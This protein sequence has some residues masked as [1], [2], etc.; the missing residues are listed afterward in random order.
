M[1]FFIKDIN[2]RVE[3][4]NKMFVI[5]DVIYIFKLDSYFCISIVVGFVNSKVIYSINWNVD[6]ES[7]VCGKDMLYIGMSFI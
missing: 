7:C 2:C 1:Y 6:W 3:I 4:M 5:V